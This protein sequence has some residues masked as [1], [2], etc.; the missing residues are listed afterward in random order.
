MSG[1]QSQHRDHGIATPR[2][3]LLTFA[4]ANDAADADALARI[5]WFDPDVRQKA[6]DTMAQLPPSLVSQYPTPEQFYG[7]ILAALSLQAPR[8]QPTWSSRCS[9]G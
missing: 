2:D 6:L 3:S 7:F 5:I 9:A 8:P 1:S 4:W